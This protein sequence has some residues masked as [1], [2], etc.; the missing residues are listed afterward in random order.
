V[1]K[2]KRGVLVFLWL[3][4]AA[5][6][7]PAP[8]WPQSVKDQLQKSGPSPL[9]IHSNRLEVDDAS[10]TVVFSGAVNAKKDEFV[11]TC[12]EMTVYYEKSPE[13]GDPAKTNAAEGQTRINRIVAR[14]DVN[15][16]RTQ[17]GTATADEAV[18]Y[19]KDDKVVLTGKPVVKQGKDFVEGDRITILLKENR[20]IVES[21]G[22]N[23]VK[24]VIFQGE[25]KGKPL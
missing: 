5:P 23:K 25:K 1:T 8:V 21:S 7:A 11:M 20:S 10:G 18:Y 6:A 19:Q 3:L 14:G 4:A 24:A 12:Q 17:G 16:Q 9:V 2:L 22:D 15:I 13:K